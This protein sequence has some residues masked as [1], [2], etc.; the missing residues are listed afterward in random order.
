ME[1]KMRLT[2]SIFLVLFAMQHIQF[3]NAA[4][5][6]FF[7]G[8]SGYSHRITI[9]PLVEKLAANGHNITYFSPHAPKTKYKPNPNITEIIPDN[10]FS[11]I[12]MDYD[13][14][15]IR[16]KGGV[17]AVE[18][19][20]PGYLD[21]GVKMCEFITTDKDMLNWAN[22]ASFDLVV[23]NALFNDCGFAY[24][25]KFNAPTIVFSSSSLFQWWGEVYVSKTFK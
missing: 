1:T 7:W 18:D 9:W 6:L 20:W 14:A 12:G 24:A 17:K 13:P 22:T 15:E 19:L 2:A 10:L 3:G 8:M 16:L 25:Y 4:N 11:R 21:S 23:V 5:I